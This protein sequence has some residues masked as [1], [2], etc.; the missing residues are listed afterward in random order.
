MPI[1]CL[2]VRSAVILFIFSKKWRYKFELEAYTAQLKYLSHKLS[3]KYLEV[4]RRKIATIM[5]SKMYNNMVD[6]KKANSD[7]V[8]ELLIRK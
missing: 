1:S 2:A 5:S 7:L 8:I 3:K 4:M 6:Y